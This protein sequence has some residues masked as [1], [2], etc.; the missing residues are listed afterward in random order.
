MK[1]KQGGSALIVVLIFLVAIMIIGTIA[2]RKGLINLNIATNSQVQ[3]LILQNSDAS[4]FQL[5]NPTNLIQSL[6][7]TGLF[8][9]ISNANDKNKELVFCYRG[10][11]SDFFNIGRASLMQWVDGN[12]TPT[13]N[14]LGTDGYCDAVDTKNNWFTSG[15]KAVM[16]QVAVK[17]STVGEDDPFYAR[18][19]GLDEKEGQ[20]QEAKRVKVFAVSLMPSLSS[21]NRADI[22]KCLQQHMSEVTIPD[23]T[24]APDVTNKSDLDNPLKSV[25]EC[26]TSLNVPFTTNVTEYTIAQD[27]N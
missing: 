24:A 22:N 9:Y 1:L 25:A 21:V 18:T 14:A 3:Q 23:G 17:F 12:S 16:T 7:A 8:G 26:L 10:D 20:V 2:I 4:F 13:N 19:R 15:R 6:S 27:F 11:Q 5:E